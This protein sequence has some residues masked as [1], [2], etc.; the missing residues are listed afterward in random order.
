MLGIAQVGVRIVGRRGEGIPISKGRTYCSDLFS[1]QV[2]VLS[3]PCVIFYKRSGQI[4]NFE[5]H[6][7]YSVFG[8]CGVQYFEYITNITTKAR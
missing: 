4:N 6:T 5:Y 2:C 1:I 8:G 7:P 3:T